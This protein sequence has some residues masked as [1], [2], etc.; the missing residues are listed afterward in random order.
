MKKIITLLFLFI[1]LFALNYKKEESVTSVYKEFDNILTE[2]N[3]NYIYLDLSNDYV[4]TKKYDMLKK[5]NLKSCYFEIKP[6]HE[7]LFKNNYYKFE[8]NNIEEQMINLEKYYLKI[9]EKNNLTLEKNKTMLVGIRI[10]KIKIYISNEELNNYL[11]S[12]KNIALVK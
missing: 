12:N 2:N 3:Y 8:G 5:L 9:L 1:V 7:K 6:R 10:K 11:N 4:T